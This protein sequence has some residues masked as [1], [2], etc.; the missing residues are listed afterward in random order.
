MHILYIR[1]LKNM[2]LENKEYYLEVG[3]NSSNI[4]LDKFLTNNLSDLS[5]TRIKFLIENG[6]VLKDSTQIKECATKVKLGDRYKIAIP[7]VEPS[8]MRP[9]HMPLNIIYE[10]D[11]M[12]VINKPAGLTVHPGAGNFQDTLANA[13]LAHCGDS[14]SGIG[15]VARPGIVH[16]LDKDTSGLLVVAKN[17]I[18]HHSLAAQIKDRSFKRIYT[19]IVW[20][21]PMP[22]KGT[23]TGNI[24]RS[25]VNR[26][27]MTIVKT[28]G[29]EAVTHY[30][31]IESFGDNIASKV[32]CKLETGRTHQIRVHFS[33][34]GHSLLGDQTYGNPRKKILKLLPELENFKRQALHS[35]QIHFLHPVTKKEMFFD[36]DLPEDL[37]EL[38][39]ILMSV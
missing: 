26:K 27:K 23:I 20:G 11:D 14:L 6:Y 38:L 37:E 17:D 15:G 33:S 1:K 13:L 28:G 30:S 10:D 24:A 9:T 31:V 22:V 18:A 4:R 12:L 36:S 35:K 5:R 21:M 29:K 8:E 2:N 32:E 25:S 7:P 3:A 39:N 16:R 34:K 19:A